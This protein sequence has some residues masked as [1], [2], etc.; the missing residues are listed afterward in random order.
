MHAIDYRRGLRR[1]IIG[2]EGLPLRERHQT[3][4]YGLTTPAWRGLCGQPGAIPPGRATQR[5]KQGAGQHA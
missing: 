1:V 5:C 4:R 3:T 2:P